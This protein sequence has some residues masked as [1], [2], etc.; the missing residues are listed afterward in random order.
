MIRIHLVLILALIQVIF[1]ERMVLHLATGGRGMVMITNLIDPWV[2]L[3][4][5][6]LPFW[7]ELRRGLWTAAFLLNFM[8]FLALGF[9]LPFLGVA[10]TGFPVRTLMAAW[11]GAIPLTMIAI[12][13]AG[14]FRAK[15]A[16]GTVR[17]YF[18]FGVLSQMALAVVQ[19]MGQFGTLPGALGAIYEWDFR[20][21]TVF[22][23]DNLILGRATGFYLNPNSLGIWALLAFWTSFFLLQ[24]RQRLL[25][26]A[27]SLAT[28]L[29]CQSRGTLAAFLGS[30]LLYALFW[31]LHRAG[32]RDRWRATLLG[33]ICVVPVVFL[34]TPGLTDA[35]GLR[36]V[37]VVGGALARYTSG[38]KVL[39][40]GAAADANFEG[41][42]QYWR[43]AFDYLANH[44][45]GS[46]GSP[47]MVVKVPSDNQFVA[48]LEQGS[49]YFLLAL[50]LTF[51]GGLRLVNSPLAHERLLAV[52]CLALIINGISAVPFAYSASYLFWLLVGVHLGE[53][54]Q[55]PPQE[56]SA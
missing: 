8:P 3:I 43:A 55:N 51:Y 38:A 39:S 33:I 41:R 23:P 13:C 12:G 4:L 17:L 49:F 50:L 34:A 35:G 48:V 53:R 18:L 56:E 20:F 47:E 45:F 29:L 21:K 6:I 15:E 16:L 46:L 19:T 11:N 9:I 7:R 5:V 14:T 22:Q 40:Q 44:P 54:V 37:P 2:T 32:R 10:L 25:G 36:R 52:A 26:C 28:V 30:A 31:M 24:R 42:T 1:A 27:A